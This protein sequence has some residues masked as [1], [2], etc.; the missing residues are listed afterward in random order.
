M[1]PNAYCW[2]NNR[3]INITNVVVKTLKCQTIFDWSIAIGMTTS[4]CL[5]WFENKEKI[6]VEA[7]IDK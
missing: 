4:S 6:I 2:V 5:T 1:I 3:F 7:F